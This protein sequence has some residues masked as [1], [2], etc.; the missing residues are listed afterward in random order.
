MKHSS[1][2]QMM[3]LRAALMMTPFLAFQASAEGQIDLK[4][5]VS[6]TLTYDDNV[7]RFASK[8][9]ARI[10]LGSEAMSDRMSTTEAGVN[11]DFRLSRQHFL[12]QIGLNKTSFDRFDFLNNNGSNKKV[13]WNWSIGNHLA[14]ELSMSEQ[15]SM[16]GFNDVHN[17]VLNIRTNTRSLMSLNWDFHPSWRLHVQHDETENKNGLA[18]Y[19][20]SDRN[21]AANEMLLQ[22]KT[23][24]GNLVG[25]SARQI[26]T[27]YPALDNVFNNQNQQRE[28]ALDFV[29]QPAGKTMINGRVGLVDR[30]YEV[31]KQRDVTDWIGRTNLNWQVTGKTAVQAGVARDMYAIDDLAGTY[32]VTDSL[33]LTPAWMPT[34]KITVQ[35]NMSY[36]SINYVAGIGNSREDKVKTAGLVVSYLPHEKIQTMLSLQKTKRDSSLSGNGF[37]SNSITANVR[38]DF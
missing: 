15:K 6:E 1:A 3:M 4:P 16:A 10:A 27:T 11:A 12:V 32:V 37:E 5:Y 38:V 26:D 33:S 29:W 22:Y 8:D 18:G 19:R 34:A 36:Q 28:L 13:G 35:G 14:G 9:Q 7:F 30:R 24:A 25:L 23:A 31:L 2:F 17:P 21:D 20:S